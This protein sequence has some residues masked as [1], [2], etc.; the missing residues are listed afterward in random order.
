MTLGARLKLIRGAAKQKEFA[1]T[2]Q[3]PLSTY[4]R[5]EQGKSI[6]DADLLKLVCEKYQINIEWLVFGSGPMHRGEINS[7]HQTQFQCLSPLDFEIIPLLESRV[8]ASPSGAIVTG[9]IADY[10]P[11]KKW[12]IESIVG[13]TQER[14][15]GLVLIR[16]RG[17]S[18]APTINQGEIAL[19]DTFEGERLDIKTGQIYVLTQP[20]GTVTLKRLGIG[21]SEE[22]KI[23]LICMSDNVAAFKPFHFELDP[24]RPLHSYVIGRVR[25]VGKEFD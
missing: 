1:D 24:G 5:Y 11:F 18:M 16:V 3:C 4:A 23:R 8:A 21:R 13:K 17:E 12:W 10:Y 2:I 19:V 9:E 6:P 7:Q 22:G 15:K 20:D 25:W 14:K